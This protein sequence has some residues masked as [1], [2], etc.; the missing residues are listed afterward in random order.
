MNMPG[1]N[2]F[3]PALM[4]VFKYD[5]VH[6][7]LASDI[8]L[9]VDGLR[10]VGATRELAWV[11]ARQTKSRIK[12]LGVKDASRERRLDNEP[13]AGGDFLTMK[14]KISKIVTV[15]K[16]TKYKGKILFLELK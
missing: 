1:N 4:R 9:Y 3:N 15:P 11:D 8:K 12:L 5:T 10:T 7:E 6:N 14:D 16:W 2:D 13:W